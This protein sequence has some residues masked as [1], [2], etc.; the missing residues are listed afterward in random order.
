VYLPP[1]DRTTATPRTRI[2]P[3]TVSPSHAPPRLRTR[4]PAPQSLLRAQ[5]QPPTNQARRTGLITPPPTTASVR[6]PATWIIS[7]PPRPSPRTELAEQSSYDGGAINRTQSSNEQ[8][9]RPTQ[10][11]PYKPQSRS[12]H[13]TPIYPILVATNM[14][15]YFKIED[16]VSRRSAEGKSKPIILTSQY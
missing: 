11:S 14:R 15:G 8:Q 9:P 3:R 16:G 4:H 13:L 12:R 7:N 6:P 2:P 5:S 10:S 1:S